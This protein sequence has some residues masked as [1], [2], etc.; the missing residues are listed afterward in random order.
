MMKKYVLVD[1]P[2]PEDEE[3]AIYLSDHFILAGII[4]AY[5]VVFLLG[6]M[7]L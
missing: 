2:D 6:G 5:P 3:S 7:I 4:L 1:V